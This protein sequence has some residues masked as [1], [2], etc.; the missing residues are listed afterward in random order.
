MIQTQHVIMGFPDSGKTTFLAALWH[1]L[2][3][4]TATSLRLESISGD[5]QYLN[6]IK[7]TWIKCQN[8]PRTLISSE[9]MVEMTIRNTAQNE[10]SILRLPDFSGETFQS[11][12][13]ERR[14]DSGLVEILND[15]AGILFFVKADRANDMLAVTDHNY[16]DDELDLELGAS[17]DFEPRNIPE[18]T[19]IIDLLQLLQSAPFYPSRRRLVIAVSAWDVIADEGIDPEGWIA[20]EMPMLDQFLTN[21]SRTY[22]IRICGISAQ[23]GRFEGQDRELLLEETPSERVVCVWE[24]KTGV[25]ITLPLTWLCGDDG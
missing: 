16:P 4:G 11:L 9:E 18:Q 13:T 25:D 15:A 12:V 20:R 2:D 8:V 24:A 3:V 10:I 19:R 23:G 6:E 14:C 5:M 7:N 17:G 21:A 1:V 22:E